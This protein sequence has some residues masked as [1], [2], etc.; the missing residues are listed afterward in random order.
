MS[1]PEP[2]RRA[3]PEALRDAERALV[4]K[5]R[6]KAGLDSPEPQVGF[7]L[8]GGG[9][10]SATFSLGVF[11]ALAVKGGLLGRIDF[12]STVSGGG[13]FGAFLG[14]LMTRDIV[15]SPKDAE[16]ILQEKI[17]P[18]ILKYLRENGRY[19]A[20]NGGGDALL[21][22]AVLL[23]NFVAV[24]LLLGLFVTMIFLALQAVRSG[25]VSSLEPQ[26]VKNAVDVFSTA[27]GIWWS[28]WLVLP[29]ATFLVA[30]FPLGWAYW[31]IE[32]SRRIASQSTVPTDRQEPQDVQR[33]DI[34]PLAGLL[35][36][37][38]TS[39]LL[40][41]VEDRFPLLWGAILFVTALTVFWW[42]VARWW[43]LPSQDQ[44]AAATDKKA[45]EQEDLE[46]YR[47]HAM[48][49]RLSLWLTRALV[50]TGALLAVGVIDSLGQTLYVLL[51]QS[52]KVLGSLLATTWSSIMV[53][54]GFARSIVSSFSSG[55]GGLRAK[56]SVR[57][58]AG[59][60]ALLLALLLLVSF[61]A[62]SHAVAWKL[63]R[64]EAA[65]EGLLKPPASGLWKVQVSG[66]SKT[67]PLHLTVDSSPAPSTAQKPPTVSRD[68]WPPTLGFAITFLLSI[69]LGQT[70]PF[71]SRSSHHPVYSARLTRAYLGASN[72]QRYQQ[73]R[74][75]TEVLPGDDYDL[76]R[77]W[78]APAENAA[79]IHLINV[80]INETVDGRSQ[81]QQ[82]DRKGV[83]LAF[84]PCG[85]S[86]GVEHH[87][88]VPDG[89]LPGELFRRGGSP[90][91]IYPP[92]DSG[93]FRVFDYPKVDGKPV[94]TGEPLPLGTWVGISGA[95]FSTGIGMRTSLGLSFLAGFG[96]VRLG[97]WWDAGF[98]RQP[99]NEKPG[100]R[101]ERLL[102]RLFPVQVLIVDEFL[103]RFPGT[104][105]RHWYLSDGGHFENM[106]GYELLRRRLPLIVIVDAESDA[107]YGFGG[108]ANLVRKA[109][110]DLGAEIEFM[111][112]EELTKTVNGT[113]RPYLG[114]LE[115]L[116]RGT[117][118]HGKLTADPTGKSNA[119]AALARVTYCAPE[120]PPSLLLYIKPTLTGDEPEDVLEYH[121]SHPAF[122]HETT[123]DQFFDEAQWESYRKLG[124]H[125]A[126][127]L[128]DPSGATGRW[129]S[130]LRTDGPTQPG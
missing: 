115:E 48:V 4:E 97:R 76:D 128:F 107:D 5:R 47:Y 104:A 105:R 42:A 86:A 49:S 28:P 44:T 9:I 103:A 7:G 98:D 121:R 75:V 62:L 18:G 94:F 129:W 87:A 8:S 120:S 51:L 89:G 25:L 122:P 1:E 67:L 50:I 65:A 57:L 10:R 11:Q 96:N 38:V 27:G 41:L 29:L 3:Y 116:R 19:L 24:Q 53:A 16:Q 124:Q 83:G 74:S 82:Q 72:K 60:A 45:D 69:L 114:S 26:A 77:Y 13:Y 37:F 36:V 14:R 64:P 79:P 85:L 21:A 112:D 110:L 117:R 100:I 88:V 54:A 123:G 31:L 34:H 93:S 91:E 125:I 68:Y 90:A 40:L 127:A 118:E 17:D 84:G 22:G 52:P 43:R 130:A 23:R 81:V 99:L 63:G 70:W 20:P 73:G 55:P 39:L 108:L 2:V 92:A 61:N 59:A 35:L 119:H 56:P 46:L 80:T 71:V 126:N 12:L 66:P 6:K 33:S 30:V 109:R 15:K 101:F 113:V 111:Q 78:R 58:I 102:A 106:G 32:P 95:A